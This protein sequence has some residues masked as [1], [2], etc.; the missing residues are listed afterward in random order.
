MA[1]AA[2]LIDLNFHSGAHPRMGAADVVPFIPID[3][4][5]IEDCVAMA[6]FTGVVIVAPHHWP[7]PTLI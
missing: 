3:G 6:K 1:A 7:G 5:T 4:V 2:E